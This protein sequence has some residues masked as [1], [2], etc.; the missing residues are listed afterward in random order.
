MEA[1]KN[2]RCIYANE[3][4]RVKFE[5]QVSENLCNARKVLHGSAAVLIFDMCSSAAMVVISRPGFWAIGHGSNKAQFVGVSR[6]LNT[7]VVR[8]ALIG[9]SVC[10]TVSPLHISARNA[11]LQCTMHDKTSRKL[12]G[13]GL[14][15]MVNLATTSRAPKL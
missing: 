7:T 4:G 12:L 10:V 9:S 13:H 6:N 11:L 2:I 1:L 3:G 5:V 14:H 15:D 8:P